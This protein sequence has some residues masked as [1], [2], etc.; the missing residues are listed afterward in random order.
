[1][2][3]VR[4][5]PSSRRDFLGILQHYRQ[6]GGDTGPRRIAAIVAAIDVLE[7][8]PNLGR[9]AERGM[10]ELVIG[11][12]RDSFV[13]LYRYRVEEDVVLV[14]AIRSAREAGRR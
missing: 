14:L 9:P 7:T 10:R 2:A 1:M 12:G 11:H 6:H 13:A 8:S 3:K 4:L 5:A